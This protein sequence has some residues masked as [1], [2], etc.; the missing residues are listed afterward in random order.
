[1]ELSSQFLAPAALYP[2]ETALGAPCILGWV[3]PKFVWTLRRRENRLPLQEIEPRAVG[4]LAR[5]V[6]AIPRELFRLP[7]FFTLLYF[8]R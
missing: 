5:R 2:M 7:H 4:P 3:N 1:M 6:V 8:I